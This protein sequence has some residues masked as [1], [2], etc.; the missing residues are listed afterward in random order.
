MFAPQYPEG[1]RLHIYAWKLDGGNHGQDIRE[2]NVLNHYIGMRDL[3][4][5]DFTVAVSDENTLRSMVNPTNGYTQTILA[6]MNRRVDGSGIRALI[7]RIREVM[8]DATL[9]TSLIV[10]FPGESD[11]QF[12]RLLAFVEE[13]RGL[14][15]THINTISSGRAYPMR[16]VQDRRHGYILNAWADGETVFRNESQN[17]KSLE[18]IVG[19]TFSRLGPE[20]TASL[21]AD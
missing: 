17:R 11:D 1:L 16:S 3:Q 12:R 4:S 7:G 13:G 6:A 5:S 10:G 19:D 9:R 15:F 14:V 21:L 20:A 18:K 2:I 8:P